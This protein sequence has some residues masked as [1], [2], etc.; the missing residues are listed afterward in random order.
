MLSRSDDVYG[1]YRVA[2]QLLR[3]CYLIVDVPVQVRLHLPQGSIVA[4][5]P[6]HH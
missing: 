5:D 2:A 6:A 3:G 4:F 1:S